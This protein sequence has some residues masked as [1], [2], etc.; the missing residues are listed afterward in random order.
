MGCSNGNKLL[1]IISFCQHFAGNFASKTLE[2]RSG[3]QN[4]FPLQNFFNRPS[5]VCQPCGLRWR[6]A[7]RAMLPAEIEVANEHRHRVAHIFQLLA[8]AERA[9]REPA[10]ERP[11]RQVCALNVTGCR[12]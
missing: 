7:D 3:G 4:D 9:A 10:R 12:G 5:M 1:E 11:H 8:K 6:L 2:W